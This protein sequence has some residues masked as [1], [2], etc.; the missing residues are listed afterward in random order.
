LTDA[1]IEVVAQ[2]GDAKDLL[3]R[4]SPQSALSERSTRGI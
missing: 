4:S 3:W 2:A 1:G